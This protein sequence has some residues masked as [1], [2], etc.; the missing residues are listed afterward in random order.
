MLGRQTQERNT[1]L[2]R[3]PGRWSAGAC[4]SPLRMLDWY[5]LMSTRLTS[6]DATDALNRSSRREL[7]GWIMGKTAREGA[8]SHSSTQTN[9]SWIYTCTTC[10]RHLCT[11]CHAKEI[12]KAPV[13][14]A[15]GPTTTPHTVAPVPPEHSDEHKPRTLAASP[16]QVGRSPSAADNPVDPK[17]IGSQICGGSTSSPGSCDASSESQHSSSNPKVVEQNGPHHPS[18]DSPSGTWLQTERGRNGQRQG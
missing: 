6:G 11:D 12:G 9:R 16:L 8:A 2:R 15:N 18:S 3:V 13:T 14:R 7:E 1:P 4:G 5:G 17:R 10:Q